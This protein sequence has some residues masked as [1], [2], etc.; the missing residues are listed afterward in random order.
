MELLQAIASRRSIRAFKP[1]AIA[2]PTLRQLLQAANQ[3]PS[4]TNTQP[5]EVALVTGASRDALSEILLGLASSG[6]PAR[7][8]VP[9]PAQWPQAL[10]QRASEHNARR[11]RVLGIGRDD[12]QAREALRLK[13]YRFFDAPCVVFLFMEREL[14]PWST[15]DMGLF[16]QN[17]ILS[18]HALGLGA[19]LQGA[20]THYPDAV[21]DFLG[22]PQTKK[23]V[24]GVSLGYPEPEAEIN[25]YHSS[26][27]EL[28]EFVRWYR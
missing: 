8:D 23:L 28:D 18:A 16:A 15:L 6:T 26:R 21:R 22:L 9:S 10:A 14:G 2:E 4:Y 19:C 7:S 17:L 25:S 20:L 13:N 11:F 27:R 5:W 24:L 3:S 1:D 12:T